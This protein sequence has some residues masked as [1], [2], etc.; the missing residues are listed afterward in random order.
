MLG[1]PR[2]SGIYGMRLRENIYLTSPDIP[3]PIS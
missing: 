3:R 2:S 1:E